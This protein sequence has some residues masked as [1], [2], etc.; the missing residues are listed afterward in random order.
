MNTMVTQNLKVF[1]YYEDILT[2]DYYLN[3]PFRLMEIG[4]YATGNAISKR[5]K[6]I[7]IN[8]HN[9]EE[10]PPGPLPVLPLRDKIFDQYLL[11]SVTDRLA[12][13]YK[14]F[15]DEFFWFWPI[16]ENNIESDP[17]LQCL[18]DGDEKQSVQIWIEKMRE[19][20]DDCAI[21]NLTIYSHMEALNQE[22]S[23]LPV[24]N[25]SYSSWQSGQLK[26]WKNVYRR[27]Q[28][29]QKRSGLWERLERRAAQI[30]SVRLGQSFLN[31]FCESLMFFVF[32][33]NSQIV[34]RLLD[35]NPSDDIDRFFCIDENQSHIIDLKAALSIAAKP[36]NTRMKA[37]VQEIDL[38]SKKKL[39]G[40]DK[41]IGDLIIAS[42]PA[43]RVL[44]AI[45]QKFDLPENLIAIEQFID[46]TV[47]TI[48]NYSIETSNWKWA[49]EQINSLKSFCSSNELAE[50]LEKTAQFLQ[51]K[52]R[53][54]NYWHREGYYN[55]P[56]L[57]LDE[58]ESAHVLLKE[59]KYDE[60][61]QHLEGLYSKVKP[62][63]ELFV[64]HALAFVLGINAHTTMVQTGEILGQPTSVQQRLI[65][66]LENQ[67]QKLVLPLYF[68]NQFGKISPSD[69]FC[70]ACWSRY[71][72]RFY[73]YELNDLK[74]LICQNCA[75]QED[76]ENIQKRDQ[77]TSSIIS[78]Y[79]KFSYAALCNPS[80][81]FVMEKC[82]ELKKLAA[83]MN[84][85]LPQN[86]PSLPKKIRP[87]KTPTS[88]PLA[89][90][91]KLNLVTL[92]CASLGQRFSA[93]LVDA[94][95]I[96]LLMFLAPL[97]ILPIFSWA[98]WLGYFPFTG[99]VYYLTTY[100]LFRKT[101]GEKGSR[102]ETK[103][104]NGEKPGFPVLLWRSLFYC[105][106]LWIYTQLCILAIYL[107]YVI[108][109]T[110][111]AGFCYLL[112]ILSKKRSL[113]EIVSGTKLVKVG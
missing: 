65:S 84:I 91:E 95:M 47:E 97:S 69:M 62:E 40:T 52:I 4:V 49:L 79:K 2:P 90:D 32:F 16:Q 39:N 72:N 56:N 94:I 13:P 48:R 30:D 11:S 86:S 82:A 33:I 77:L 64:L 59:E 93:F 10:I 43:M 15:F 28:N 54:G 96:A 105:F 63:Y 66:N 101:L 41:N 31:E 22:L 42:I 89:K 85:T 67:N 19:E 53:D 44:Q 34:I 88:T 14:R 27:F 104:M 26:R 99:L 38:Q 61:V 12:D 58:L 98:D 37:F 92:S 57:L 60:C 74:M 3:N 68:L 111:I 46:K 70:M 109:V 18:R 108:L 71:S 7:E 1:E 36:Y 76:L 29:L 9:N 110:S 5:K 75:S 103:G 78:A 21:H 8:L 80:N 45:G 51:V 20:G 81:Q 102:I 73:V 6:L 107:D 83:E 23:S 100:L 24:A 113:P 35:Q 112:P 55:L 50:E 87:Q 17:A 25:P 106:L